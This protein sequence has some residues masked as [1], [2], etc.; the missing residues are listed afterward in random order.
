MSPIRKR[1]VMLLFSLH[2]LIIGG[3]ALTAALHRVNPEGDP[4]KGLHLVNMTMKREVRLPWATYCRYTALEADYG[5]FSPEIGP[6]MRLSILVLLP[7][8]HLIRF[9]TPSKS[10]ESN[11]RYQTSLLALMG[12]QEWRELVARSHAARAIDRHPE[13]HAVMVEVH[14]FA[15]PTPEEWRGGDRGEWVTAFKAIFANRRQQPETMP[16]R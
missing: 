6:A 2:L 16:D 9:D 7:G 5:F 10:P 8:D 1:I 12:R 13:A 3:Y 4:D 14:A 15:V 11:Y